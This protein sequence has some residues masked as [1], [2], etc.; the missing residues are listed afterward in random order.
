[1]GGVVGVVD[2]T[3]MVDLVPT[4]IAPIAPHLR[5]RLARWARELAVAHALVACD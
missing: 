1:M 5:D 4:S 3:K 2:G